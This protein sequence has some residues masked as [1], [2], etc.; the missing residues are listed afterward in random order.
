MH[1]L[2]AT[3]VITKQRQEDLRRLASPQPFIPL[4]DPPIGGFRRIA[5]RVVVRLGRWISGPE[6]GDPTPDPQATTP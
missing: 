3:F 6:L 1:N 5:G 2:D 4:T